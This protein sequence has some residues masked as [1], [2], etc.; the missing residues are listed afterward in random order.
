M[1]LIDVKTSTYNDLDGQPNIK[2]FKFKVGD[3]VR[4]SKYKSIFAKDYKRNWLE[5]IFF[6]IMIG[7]IGV[8]EF[9]LIKPKNHVNTLFVIIITSLK[10]ILYSSQNYAMVVII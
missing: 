7:L 2:D 10:Q 5:D 8:K 3:H 6:Y 1:K 4:I 9:M